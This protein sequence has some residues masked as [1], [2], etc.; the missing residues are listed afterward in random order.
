[1]AIIVVGGS[2]HGVGKTA[3]V[4]GLIAVLPEYRWNAVKIVTHDHRQ[5]A[6][7]GLFPDRS[8]AVEGQTRI[9]PHTVSTPSFRPAFGRQVFGRRATDKLAETEAGTASVA[10]W[11]ETTPGEQTD[12]A[13][14]LAAGAARAMLVFPPD[15]DLAEPL[16][17]LWP[18]FGRGTNLI[19]ESNSVV[20]HVRADACLLIHAVA[21]RTL[22]L[23]EREP[24]F[25]AALNRADAMVAHAAADEVIA[26][27]LCLAAPEAAHQKPPAPKPI[28]HLRRLE[29]IS[30]EMLAWLRLRLPPV[31][32]S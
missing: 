7:P 6:S 4:C 13:R 20:H 21:E 32:H 12:T 1:M 17:Q 30:P 14:Y 3:L 10:I 11:E 5:S 22:P 19:F 9:A 26:D 31:Q 25:I 2:N 15:G 28:F 23:P 8:N 24:S 18:R 29:Q 27:G 16:N